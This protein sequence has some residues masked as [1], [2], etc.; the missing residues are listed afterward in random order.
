MVE[1]LFRLPGN[2]K[3][4]FMFIKFRFR[5]EIGISGFAGRDARPYVVTKFRTQI[6]SRFITG[7]YADSGPWPGADRF[8]V[9]KHS[10]AKIRFVSVTVF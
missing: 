5:T 2:Q 7:K 10:E 9:R 1:H 4:R 8:S 3:F 6:S